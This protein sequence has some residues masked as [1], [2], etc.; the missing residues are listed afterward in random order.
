[1]TDAAVLHAD[2]TPVRMLDPGAGKT[3]KAYV[4]A[5]ARSAFDAAPGV[6][7][8]FCLGRGSQYPMDFLAERTGTL[9]CDDYSGYEPVLR[10]KGRIEAG[11][12]AHARRKFDELVKSNQSSVGTEAVQRIAWL[13]KFE[14]EARDLAP[15][16]RLAL[17]QQRSKPLWNDLHAW[18]KLER[19]RV[20]DGSGIAGALDYSLNRWTA[21]GSSCS[22]VT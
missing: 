18:L 5:Y 4:W 12:V 14:R 20:P 22:M 9:V 10:R 8:D 21:L 3:K 6:V 11:C 15:A 1:M 16:D 19:A 7:Y 13:Y 17:R 2:E